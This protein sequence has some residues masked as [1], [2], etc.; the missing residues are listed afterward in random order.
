MET[1]L[2]KA[3]NYLKGL[4]AILLCSRPN[5]TYVSGYTGSDALLLFTESRTILFVDS[6]NTTQAKQETSSDVYEIKRRWEDI[7]G[8]L[9]ELG[10][11]SLGIESNI[12]DVDSFLQMKNLFVGIEMTPLGKQL[13]YLRAIKEE[14][15]IRC[16]LKAAEVAENA[17]DVVLNKGIVSRRERDVSLDL[18]WEMRIRGAQATSFELIVA[19]GWRSALP[20]GVASEKVI[21]SG[22]PVIIDFGCVLD[23]Y[24]S[25]ETITL[26]TG[27]P[28]PEFSQVY[29]H[30]RDAQERAIK[31]VASGCKAPDIDKLARDY[32]ELQGI[33]AY[34]GHGLGHGVG[35]EVHEMPT[36]SPLSDDVLAE[37]MVITIEP[38]VYLPGKYG[39]R[40]ED[41]VLVRDSSCKRITN[42]DKGSIRVIN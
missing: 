36:I 25:D 16:L 17:L 14:L 9:K 28:D 12:L 5:I 40:L 37:G 34:F 13:R 23:G 42:I 22:E 2:S 27:E 7:A 30:V 38:G 4:D 32:L 3:R 41:T 10:I 35:M 8:Y 33:A 21:E 15:E 19:S 1:R 26:Y 6:R 31:G 29:R 18:E 11:H 24:C 20:H 39:V